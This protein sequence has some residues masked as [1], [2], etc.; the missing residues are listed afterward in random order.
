MSKTQG[1]FAEHRPMTFA[2]NTS[3]SP[4]SLGRVTSAVTSEGHSTGDEIQVNADGE[5]QVKKFSPAVRSPC[6]AGSS[7]AKAGT[8]GPNLKR[9]SVASGNWK[10]RMYRR[11]LAFY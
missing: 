4:A 5:D 11:V 7:S 3:G 8:A 10:L 1:C 6:Q 2:P 9:T